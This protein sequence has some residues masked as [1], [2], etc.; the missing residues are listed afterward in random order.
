MLTLLLAAVVVLVGAGPAS[1][2]VGRGGTPSTPALTA[3]KAA[4][5][6]GLRGSTP[7]T[8]SALHEPT[9]TPSEVRDAAD[10][11]LD[12]AE[13]QRPEPNILDKA[14]AWVEER[15][16]RVLEKLVNGD[17]ASILGWIVLLG[18]IVAI[19][20]LL[21]RLGRS[22]QRDPGRATSVSV[23]RARTAS[24]W[25]DEAER[26]EGEGQWKL[27]LRCRFRA[28]VAGLVEQGR[29]DDVPG[30]TAGEYRTEIDTTL[31]EAAV[32]FTEATYLFEDAW[33]GD[34]PTGRA[35]NER[36]RA[37][38]DAVVTAS[39]AHRGEG[40]SGPVVTE[41]EAVSA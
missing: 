14:R 26:L 5:G 2:T 21:A 35:E 31:P 13:F 1:P 10:D 37:L 9:W 20:L 11:V 41:S 38:A 23:E 30:R 27:A 19:G 4:A 6:P 32:D 8:G 15:I 34:E 22:V 24:E 12:G 33:Y 29:V 40:A 17:G 39:D 3:S 36:F 16:G 25:A 18:S 28:L 7:S